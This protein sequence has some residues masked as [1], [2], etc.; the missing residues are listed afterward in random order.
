MFEL[1]KVGSLTKKDLNF[2]WFENKKLIPHL[3]ILSLADA[4][5]TSENEEYLEELR[6]FIIYLQSYYFD[7]Y[8]NEIVEEPLLTG[9]EIIQTLN[10]KPSPKVGEI[11]DKL[12]Q[13]Q[14]SGEI[15][16]KEEAVSF[17]KSL[18]VS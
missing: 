9:R 12:L 13:L 5:A 17:I 4:Y 16:T 1:K 3:F 8:K 18:G 10:I 14:I 15:K 6:I 2:F 11:K 7:V